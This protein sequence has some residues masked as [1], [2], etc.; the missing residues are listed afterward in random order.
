MRQRG[1]A[2]F[3]LLVILLTVWATVS[4]M[5][6]AYTHSIADK[7]VSM[8]LWEFGPKKVECP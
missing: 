7:P 6:A 8:C 1:E 2:F 3:F 5:S 4:I